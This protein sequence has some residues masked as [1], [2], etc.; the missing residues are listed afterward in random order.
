[1]DLS[2]GGKGHTFDFN[3]NKQSFM[4]ESELK[5]ED[6]HGNTLSSD[7]SVTESSHTKSLSCSSDELTTLK[8][9]PPTPASRSSSAITTHSQ[10]VTHTANQAQS[11]TLTSAQN[12]LPTT[13]S[14]YPTHFKQGSL[15]Q[16]AN[17]QMK[18][19]EDLETDDFVNSA[20]Q[21]P[22]VFLDHSTLLNIEQE[23]K[24]THGNVTL[25]FNVGKDNLEVRVLAP[26][27]HPFFVYGRSWSSVSPEASLAQ[28]GLRCG[29]LARGDVCISL[30]QSQTQPHGHMSHYQ[31]P[32]M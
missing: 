30:T 27:S 31:S 22:D 21:N 15:I 28:F 14:C 8:T 25:T 23:D 12:M 16:L 3:E 5:D 20:K 32:Q 17:G 24:S 2:S 19:V 26:A 13:T 29:Q 1:M 10:A 6:H 9:A 11:V 4:K 18:K 7:N